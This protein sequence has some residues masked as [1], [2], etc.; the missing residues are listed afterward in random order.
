MAGLCVGNSSVTGKFPAQM[1]SNA[2]NISIWWRHHIF[3]F[4]IAGPF[5][6]VHWLSVGFPHK[7]RWGRAS[8][9]F[10][11]CDSDEIVALTVALPVFWNWQNLHQGTSHGISGMLCTSTKEW[12]F[13]CQLQCD[14]D[15][16]RTNPRTCPCSICCEQVRVVSIWK[17]TWL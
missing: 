6:G 3:A 12:Q 10:L 2:E 5:S 14:S 16:L 15:T 11:W 4:R 9:F 13:V 8:M 7:R 17:W 1:A